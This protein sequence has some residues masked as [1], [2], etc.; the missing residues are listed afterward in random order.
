MP[1]VPVQFTLN[2]HD[3]AEFIEAGSTLLTA[4][5]DKCGDTSAKGGC[6][7]GT[8]GACS[9]IIDGEL[10]LSCLTLAETC[11]GAEIRTAAGLARA[12]ALAPLQQAFLDG[13][14]TQCGFCAPGM[15]MAATTLL[16]HTPDPTR[17]QV[18]EAL[19]GN[20]CRCTGY[21]PIIGAVLAA[22][23]ATAA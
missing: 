11:Q 22:A 3:R 20:I 5:R 17:A 6:H 4:L 23:R 10:R 2:G 1:K 12:G 16:E 15:L 14:A 21:E 7:Q 18:I 13:F 9:V 8:C 19:S